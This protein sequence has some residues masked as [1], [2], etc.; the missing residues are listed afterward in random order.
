MANHLSVAT[1]IEKNRIASDTAFVLLLDIVIHDNTGAY[2]ETLHLAKNSENLVYLGNEYVASNFTAQIDIQTGSDPKFQL[3][4]QDPT[5][6]LRNRME[7]YGGGVGFPVTVTVVNSGNLTQ[8]PEISDQ[9]EVIQASA[10]GYV[11]SFT[12]GIENP[13]SQRF[14]SRLM[15]KDQ[16]PYPYKGPRCKYTGSLATCDFTLRGSNGCDVHLN[17]VN[18]GGFPGLQNGPNG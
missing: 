5:G 12:L 9:F 16:C 11:V 13:I 8:S 1:A 14:P 18:F 17:T 7:L 10:Q 15:W 4:A 2:V 6:V 3:V